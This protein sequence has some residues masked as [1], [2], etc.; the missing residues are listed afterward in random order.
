M[1]FLPRRLIFTGLIVLGFATIIATPAASLKGTTPAALLGGDITSIQVYAVGQEAPDSNWGQ[2]RAGAEQ[3]ET[4]NAELPSTLPP[5]EQDACLHC[6]IEG[7][8]DNEWSPISRWFVFG[9]MGLTFIFG[10][11]RNFMVWRTRDR[12]HDRWINQL[13]KVAFFFFILQA[14]TGILL[15]TLR[16]STSESIVQVAAVIKAI[17]WGSGLV[18]FIAALAL[19][20]AGALLPWYQRAFWGMIFITEIVGSTFAI[21]NLSF[22]FLYSEWHDPPAPGRLYGFHMLLIPVAIAGMMSIYFVMQR[23]RGEI[24]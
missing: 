22:I 12:W 6:H 24:Q 2:A 7:E 18:L 1:K 9:A 15:L 11:T 4:L 13:S 20:F 17:H 23:K 19:S 8:I 16:L 3:T 21:A 14:T 10:I 5:P